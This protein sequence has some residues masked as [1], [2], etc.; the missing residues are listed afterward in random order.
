[1]ENKFEIKLFDGEPITVKL[2]V[3]LYSVRDFMGKEMSG[4]AIELQSLGADNHW[5][6]FG[7][8][9]KNFGEYIGIKNAV[10]IDTNNCP[11]VEE[12][13]EKGIAVE[14]GFTKS[15][16]FCLYPLWVFNSE[17]LE[18]YGGDKYKKYSKEYDEYMA[19][20]K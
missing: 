10:Y 13:L 3:K 5:N 2:E 7:P 17:F 1:M 18:A 16:G 20:F 8:I 14:T 4:L 19:S 12:L 15:S 9:S 11:Y 6:P